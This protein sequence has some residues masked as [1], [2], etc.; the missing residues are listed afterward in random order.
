MRVLPVCLAL[1]LLGCPDLLGDPPVA[2]PKPAAKTAPAKTAP[3]KTAPAKAAAKPAP[4]KP[5]KPA[6]EP[7]KIDR[8]ALPATAA[9]LSAEHTLVMAFAEGLDGVLGELQR[10]IGALPPAMLQRLPPALLNASAP[11]GLDL[12][13]A[14]GWREA[15]VDPEVGLALAQDSRLGRGGV[16]TPLLV[17]KPTDRKVFEATLAKL[18]P[19][20]PF[21]GGL[22]L[23]DTEVLIAERAGFL[24]MAPVLAPATRATVAA[25]MKAVLADTA[26]LIASPTFGASLQVGANRPRLG[27]YAS[28]KKLLAW[29]EVKDPDALFYAERVLG[30]GHAFS[31]DGSGGLRLQANERAAAAL[32]SVLAPEAPPPA[33]S[34]HVPG[35]EWVLL[36]LSANLSTGFMG[37]AQLIPPSQAAQRARIALAPT[38][39]G[40]ATGVPWPTVAETLS[41]QIAAALKLPEGKGEPRWLVMLGLKKVAGLETLLKTAI[42][43]GVKVTEQPKSRRLDFAKFGLRKSVFLRTA[44]DVLLVAGDEATLDA[45]KGDPKAARLLDGPL[46]FGAGAHLEALKARAKAFGADST[47][48]ETVTTLERV[49]G[50]YVGDGL[51]HFGLKLEGQGLMLGG[52]PGGAAQAI[53]VAALGSTIFTVG[54]ASHSVAVERVQPAPQP[55]KTP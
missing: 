21:E 38:A 43:Q 49:A 41:G 46:A 39:I 34:K 15:G 25:G 7:V 5:R 12:S 30:V 13:S 18:G 44:G 50:P 54:Q 14:K 4:T 48:Q 32:K 47:I 6:V 3:A 35:T 9:V 10:I 11:P 2:P 53:W 16:P 1:S 22:K 17:L 29:L 31:P 37:A 19:V 55:L 28:P 52:G 40:M 42:V 24:L 20:T 8:A 23:G 45:A 27:G 26:P 33:F 36:R 51:L